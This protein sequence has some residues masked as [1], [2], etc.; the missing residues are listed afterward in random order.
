MKN[1]GATRISV[2]VTV[3]NEEKTTKK[4][5]AAL[6]SQSFQPREIIVVDGGSTDSTWDILRRDRSI[7]PFRHPGNRSTG[8]NFAISQCRSPIIA[9]TDAGCIPDKNWLEE[10][11]RPFT[12]SQVQIVSGYYRAD[13]KNVFQKCLAPYVLVM[14][15]VASRTEFFPSTRSMAIRKAV[16]EK[17]KFDEKLWHNED[18]AY[19]HSLK[20]AGFSFHFAPRA[21][22]SWTPRQTLGEAAWMFLRFAMGDI[23]AG[24]I[25]PQVKNLIIRYLVFVY[26]FF[27]S[28]EFRPLFPILILTS[29]FYILYSIFK[30]YRYVRDLRAIYWLP[31]LQVTADVSVIT[32]SIIGF[33][34][35]T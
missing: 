35:K 17:H 9:M 34:T 26:L 11:A 5:I 1:S 13:A 3:F 30:N 33:W 24:I 31:I 21:I 22:V 12:D 7:K 4:L 15:D 32:G 23:Q 6:K 27:L 18:Y 14:P 25:R 2:I 29:I 20:R 19:A 28:L 8:R 16:W 10:L